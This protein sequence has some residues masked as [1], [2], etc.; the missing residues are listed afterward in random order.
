M[1][2]N[3][4]GQNT[5][6]AIKTAANYI[7]ASTLNLV[8]CDLGIDAASYRAGPDLSD[9]NG[10]FLINDLGPND[11]TLRPRV[12]EAVS[13]IGARDANGDMRYLVPP[14]GGSNAVWT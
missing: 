12:L 11:K 14:I 3:G 4:W 7:N 9:Y 5:P 13:R 1:I 8:W 6:V 2:I 10:T